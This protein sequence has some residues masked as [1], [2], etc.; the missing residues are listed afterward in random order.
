MA[1]KGSAP[2]AEGDTSSAARRPAPPPPE[3]SFEE[4]LAELEARVARLERGDLQLEEALQLYE[5]GVALIRECQSRL[6]AADARI[7]ALTAAGASIPLSG[8]PDDES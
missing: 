7:V 4:A 8:E 1:R 5:Q 3:R 6:D 2:E